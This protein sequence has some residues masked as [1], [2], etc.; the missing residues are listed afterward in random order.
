MERIKEDVVFVKGIIGTDDILLD[1]VPHVAFIGRS[2]AGKS[3]VINTLIERKDF[4]KSSSTPGKTQEI[5]FF[6]V[7]KKI[8]FVDLP[9]YGYA[10]VSP[11]RREKLKKMILWYL[12]C[13]GVVPRVT[14]LI[15][16]AQVGLTSNDKEMLA[17]LQEHEYRTV[18]VA[19][20][21]DR[22]NQKERSKQLSAISDEAKGCV[23]VAH[24]ATK[25]IGT[26]ELL[27]TIGEQMEVD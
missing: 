2:N 12:F 18:I 23:V 21:I 16:D 15:V 17:L 9:G 6:K 7:N 24:S 25:R 1:E 5:N 14:V 3:S 11:K 27:Q 13:S 20:K 4:V 19:N 10:K 26:K 8:Y 22:L